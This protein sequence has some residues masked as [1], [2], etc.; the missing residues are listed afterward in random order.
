MIKIWKKTLFIVLL[1]VIG[2]FLTS[3][4]GL[5]DNY[6]EFIL[7][8]PL[9]KNIKNV[10]SYLNKNNFTWNLSSSKTKEKFSPLVCQRRV[11]PLQKKIVA[12]DQGWK[13][14]TCRQTL[15][16]TYEV[17]HIQPL[18]QGGSNDIANLQALCRG[19]H[20]KKTILANLA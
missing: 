2:Y 15:D 7:L 5:V 10:I 12:S 1:I 8:F 3:Y 18:F 6:W 20:G 17:D 19:C 9:P 4:L 16:Y 14:R 13:C 11:T